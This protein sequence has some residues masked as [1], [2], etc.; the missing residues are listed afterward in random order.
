MTYGYGYG[1]Q[2]AELLKEYKEGLTEEQIKDKLGIKDDII[3][4]PSGGVMKCTEDIRPDL[5]I[6]Q[7]NEIII[8]VNRGKYNE[9]PLYKLKNIKL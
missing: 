7:E 9:K 3:N 4:V 5:N 8:D 1:K 2:I 6:L